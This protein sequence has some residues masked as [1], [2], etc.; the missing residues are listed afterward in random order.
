MS[1]LS[2]PRFNDERAAYEW[3]EARLW[4]DGPV[5]PHCRAT[6]RNK[7]LRAVPKTHAVIWRSKRSPAV[8]RAASTAMTRDMAVP[9]SWSIRRRR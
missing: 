5:C 7:R 9:P 3:V 8:N 4:P 6:D 2:H 1:V